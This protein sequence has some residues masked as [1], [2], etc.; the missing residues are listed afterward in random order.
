MRVVLFGATGPVGRRVLDQPVER[1]H[2]VK[3]L[4]GD[5]TEL[6]RKSEMLTVIEGDTADP[7]K[8]GETI[9][10]CEAV[11][12]TLGVRANTE[13]EVQR[14]LKVTGL[15]LTTMRRYGVR[16]FIGVG[17]AGVDVPG[18]RRGLATGWSHGSRS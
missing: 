14:L 16:R 10:G 5:P 17:G 2:D 13:T 12:D 8:V 7:S 18:T 11:I 15:I 3:V 6:N 4:V 9:A 1:D